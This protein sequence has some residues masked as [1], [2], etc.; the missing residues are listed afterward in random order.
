MSNIVAIVGRPNVGKSTF[1]NRLVQ[2]RQAIVEETSG[3]TRDRHYGHSDWN[4][5]SFTV[6]DTGGYVVGSDDI[7]EAEIR[8]QVNL[9][10]DEADVIIFVV[11]GQEGLHP[12]DEDVAAILRRC[13]KHV[14][15]ASNKTDI[16]SKTNESS[17]FY[18]LG[19]GEVYAISAMTGTGTGDLLDEVVKVLPDETTEDFS[20]LPRFAIVGRPNVGK[21]SMVNAFLGTERNIVTD[22]AGTT[23]D[24]NNTRFN[25]FGMDFIL[26]DTAG[27]RKK[28]KVSENIEFYSVMRSIRAIEECDVA[29]LIIDATTGFEAQDMNIL[30]LIERNKKG[31]VLVVNKWDLV[32]K[33]SNTHIEYERFIKS[34]T[35]PFTDYTIVFTSAINRQRTYKLLETVNQVYKNRERKISTREINDT[36][37]P[38]IEAMPPSTASRG[39]Y[40]KI[41]YIT[42]LKS[43]TPQFVFFCNLPKDVKEQYMRFL[44]GKIRENWN[45]NGVPIQLFFR[46]K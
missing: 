2:S 40:I 16:P 41:K 35:A 14:F 43:P 15:L 5:K 21:S 42:Q 3:V 13:K 22:I 9:A 1:F 11:D 46:E 25:A 30:R 32:E 45:F 29:I 18:A 12:L 20:N 7:F 34:K 33:D 37:L 44:E 19:L 10:I 38:I 24:A 27:L 8:K 6:I 39:R 17:E 31:L 26:V 36:L 28:S 23:R 4:G